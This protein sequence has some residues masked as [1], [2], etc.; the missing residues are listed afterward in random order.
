[1][2]RSSRP[3]TRTPRH[4]ARPGTAAVL[5]ATG[6]LLLTG[7]GT[8]TGSGG[9]G[10]DAGTLTGIIASLPAAVLL[11]VAQRYVAAGVTSGAV[12]D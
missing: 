3:L 2:S 11:V 4:L 12:K 10:G 5:A 1:M 6:A 8:G 7:C 9:S